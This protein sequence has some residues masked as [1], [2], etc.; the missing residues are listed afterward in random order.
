MGFVL[1]G[2]L[3]L[4]AEENQEESVSGDGVKEG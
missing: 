3:E 1:V 4:G 2:D